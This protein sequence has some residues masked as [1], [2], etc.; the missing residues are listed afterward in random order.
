MP[1]CFGKQRPVGVKWHANKKAWMT[2]KL[3][4]EYLTDLD[5]SMRRQNRHILLFLDNAPVHKDNRCYT[6][7]TLK[8]FPPNTTAGTQPLDAGI[9]RNFKYLYRKYL[10]EYLIRVID[11]NDNVISATELVRHVNVS[12]A[13]SWLKHSWENIKETTIINCFRHVG[14]DVP[15]S[16]SVQEDEINEEDWC[17]LA[18]DLDIDEAVFEEDVTT[19]YPDDIG[20]WEQMILSPTADI[21]EDSDADDSACDDI[22]ELENSQSIVKREALLKRAWNAFREAYYNCGYDEEYERIFLKYDHHIFK[23]CKTVQKSITDYFI[24]L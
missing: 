3:F 7:I 20:N 19:C 12:Q 18:S 5:D 14:F 9:I 23:R 6:N 2:T 22:N 15:T 11:N 13:I 24:K 10:M 21:E 8:F 16:D 17:Q 1:R 4:Q